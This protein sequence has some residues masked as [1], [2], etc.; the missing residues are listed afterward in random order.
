[1]TVFHHCRICGV[2]CKV[3]S[4]AL[5]DGKSKVVMDSLCDSKE[6]KK[7]DLENKNLDKWL[8]K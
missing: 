4:N 6:C 2:I 7:K 3:D 1:M 8:K 5:I